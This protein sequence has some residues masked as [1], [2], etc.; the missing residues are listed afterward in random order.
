MLRSVFH[1]FKDFIGWYNDTGIFLRRKKLKGI[2]PKAWRGDCMPTSKKQMEKLNRAKKAK[3]EE[4]SKQAASG[5]ES[6]KKKLK[7]LQKKIK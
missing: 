4:L 2:S 6:A 7:K 1:S 3:A 5:S